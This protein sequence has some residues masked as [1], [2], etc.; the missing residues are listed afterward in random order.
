MST[1]LIRKVCRLCVCI[2]FMLIL[3]VTNLM[4]QNDYWLSTTNIPGN[5]S[6]KKLLHQPGIGLWGVGSSG[7]LFWDVKTQKSKLY[8]TDD[9]GRVVSGLFDIAIAHDTVYV[10]SSREL[11]KLN[12]A[13]RLIRV[14]ILLPN[15]FLQTWHGIS[16]NGP[17]L[18]VA[19]T[20]YVAYVENG[21]V[22]K[23]DSR[24]QKSGRVSRTQ[25]KPR[26]N[27]FLLADYGEGLVM[28]SSLYEGLYVQQ[29]KNQTEKR[30]TTD[31]AVS[32]IYQKDVG[33]WI[34]GE[35]ELIFLHR[36]SVNPVITQVQ[37]DKD[38]TKLLALDPQGK[39]LMYTSKAVYTATF[40]PLKLRGANPAVVIEPVAKPQPVGYWHKQQPLVVVG[41]DEY[42][43]AEPNAVYHRKGSTNKLV[44]EN[45]VPASSLAKSNVW[46]P[47]GYL[48]SMHGT[49][50][51]W[52][53]YNG[54]QAVKRMLDV[55]YGQGFFHDGKRMYVAKGKTIYQRDNKG[56]EKKLFE[57]P[58]VGP[59]NAYAT[60][61]GA[62]YLA[63]KDGIGIYTKGKLD[64]TPLKDIKNHPGQAV[65]S[66]AVSSNNEIFIYFS[67]PYSFN[68]VTKEL[69][70]GRP[71]IGGY[72][73]MYNSY[74]DG[75]GGMYCI[76]IGD[77]LYYN[78]TEWA[79]LKN[80]IRLEK[81]LTPSDYVSVKS[82]AV[83]YKGRCW[84][85]CSFKGLSYMAVLEKGKIVETFA[86]EQMPEIGD[87]DVNLYC[88]DKDLMLLSS[89][90]GITI[91]KLK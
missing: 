69:K 35:R 89:N 14:P 13:G 55:G 72:S 40:T 88:K 48:Y 5:S 29:K 70:P 62:I 31:N 91:Y 68:P 27:A 83:D 82:L 30:I 61:D 53:Q 78:G 71:G 10:L 73:F 26:T 17:V 21:R 79:D 67:Q 1:I 59:W 60:P 49:S 65:Q 19:N 66:I 2:T 47:D 84:M 24:Y 8:N 37:K 3:F 16:S 6:P 36:D 77:A 46:M 87:F 43:F 58:T 9:S 80:I 22:T 81:G 18:I 63:G 20:S 54:K 41:E 42:Y 51:T 15:D 52:Y 45:P 12:A 34:L 85:I 90:L 38:T 56:V 74:N 32:S 39:V 33:L 75:Y 25:S 57:M 64:F 28:N 11:Y 86:R 7:L 4:A 76:G 23:R 50:A 44:V